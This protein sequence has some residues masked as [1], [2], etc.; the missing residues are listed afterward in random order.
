MEKINGKVENEK[1]IIVK[2]IASSLRTKSTI[3]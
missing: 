3:K 2:P 1:K